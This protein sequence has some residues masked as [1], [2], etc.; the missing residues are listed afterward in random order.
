MG[1]VCCLGRHEGN[2]EQETCPLA[3][4]PSPLAGRRRC[5]RGGRLAHGSQAQS[6]QVPPA[7][8]RVGASPHQGMELLSARGRLLWAIPGSRSL[9]LQ[10][11]LLWVVCRQ[12][13]L[14]SLLRR[15]ACGLVQVA[16]IRPQ[17]KA[18]K[19]LACALP[20]SPATGVC[21]APSSPSPQDQCWC[22]W[23]QCRGG[24]RW[25]R[26]E[27]GEQDCSRAAAESM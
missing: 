16:A 27:Q 25:E 26:M 15:I 6:P 5:L 23:F 22:M 11:L 7:S 24:E 20:T 8:H 18:P 10:W 17:R 19:G 3:C 14:V 12:H 1:R 21:C 13:L 4:P 2:D 9:D